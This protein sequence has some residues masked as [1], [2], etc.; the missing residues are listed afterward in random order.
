MFLTE[1]LKKRKCGKH[2][3]FKK[4]KFN[5]GLCASLMAI[6]GMC[7]FSTD[8][9]VFGNIRD[10][11][12][13]CI[14]R[15][16][17]LEKEISKRN[18]NI[19]ESRNRGIALKND[20]SKKSLE[21]ADASVK[22]EN[23]Q[24]SINQ[25]EADIQKLK[26]D[27]ENCYDELSGVLSK[28]Y[29]SGDGSGVGSMLLELKESDNY[30]DDCVFCN[31]LGDYGKDVVENINKNKNELQN[32]QK[33]LEANKR[34]EEVLKAELSGQKVFLERKE[35]E[36]VA[37]MNVLLKEQSEARSKLSQVEIERKRLEEEWSRMQARHSQKSNL[38]RGSG[39][40]IW[41]VRGR[42]TSPFGPR[43]GRMHKGIDIGAPCGAPVNAAM[44]G[45]IIAIGFDRYGYGNYIM[46]DHG[47][48]YGTI[49][50][51]LS[52]IGVSQGQNVKTGQQIGRVGSTGRST[53][54]HLHFGVLK[55]GVW[56]NPISEL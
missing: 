8:T 18:K 41:P 14:E 44:N 9:L 48:G 39:R 52:S 16:S 54:P 51:H 30:I 10:D 32:K 21:I 55:N 13:K 2:V 7:S 12:I 31:S 45:T 34:N 38:V 28:V 33:E 1:V 47:S 29:R 43:W 17:R 19:K 46:I 40:Y 49:Y 26:E 6:I 37:N 4:I 42:I 22:L 53:G 3:K 15:K 5:K 23:I 27:L 56:Y 36:N 24:N 25:N 11:Y 50:A 20:I 35:Q